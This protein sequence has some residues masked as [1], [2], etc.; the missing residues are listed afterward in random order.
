M[1]YLIQIYE[2]WVDLIVLGYHNIFLSAKCVCLILDLL[3][4]AE[5][6]KLLRKPEI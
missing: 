2:M 1:I 5:F 3:F 4:G 6:Q